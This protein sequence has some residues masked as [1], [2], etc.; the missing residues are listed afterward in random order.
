MA[1]VPTEDC[2]DEEERKDEEIVADAKKIEDDSLLDVVDRVRKDMAA[3][4][5]RLDKLTAGIY[6]TSQRIRRLEG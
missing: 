5:E 6:T 3:Q 2:N 1:D 4:K